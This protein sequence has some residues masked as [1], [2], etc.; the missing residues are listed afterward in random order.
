MEPKTAAKIFEEISGHLFGSFYGPVDGLPIGAG[1]ISSGIP[2][3]FFDET[4]KQYITLRGLVYVITH[5][6][7]VDQSNVRPYNEDV[8]I[9]P[10]I[11]LEE[12][13]SDFV[14]RYGSSKLKSFLE[15]ASR[16]TVSRLTYLPPIKSIPYGGL[17]YL[18]WITHTRIE[19]FSGNG[20]K[21][22]AALSAK[23]MRGLDFILQQ[24]LFRPKATPLFGDW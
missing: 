18:N 4:S 13:V 15:N 17:L 22:E 2:Y 14:T 3:P 21:I 10:I 1:L 6:C 23:G 11:P 8:L 19:V 20:C 24:H 7:D 5:E 16:G 9:C 12:F